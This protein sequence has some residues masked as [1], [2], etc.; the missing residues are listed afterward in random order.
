MT[1]ESTKQKEV[2]TV[3]VAIII[4]F[5]LVAA[6]IFFKPGGAVVPDI[7]TPEGDTGSPEAQQPTQI[8]FRAIDDTDH[9]RGPENAKV[10][11]LE[12]SDL[13]C[14]FC[15]NF[16]PTLEK[17]MQEYPNDVRW[18]Y[19][20][21]PL[22]SIHPQARLSAIASECAAEQGKF[23][24][25]ID[26]VFGNTTSGADLVQDKLVEYAKIAGVA[27]QAQFAACLDAKKYDADVTADAT[28]AQTA[29]SRGTPYTL[30]LGPNDTKIPISGALPYEQVKAQ[31][32]SALAN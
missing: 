27:N 22:E 25:Y 7:N 1:E 9:V 30:I 17:V 29:G 18:V 32:D 11:L 10:T 15:R 4:G 24:E 23:W 14:P 8:S 28:D 26:Y 3:P 16:H 12:Y 31:L 20:H 13:E 21:F 2:I 19:R 6:A 5:V